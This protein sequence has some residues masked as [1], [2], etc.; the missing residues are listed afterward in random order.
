MAKETIYMGS[1]HG[2]FEFKRKLIGLLKSRGYKLV[3]VGPASY[4]KEDDFV[5][6]A[7]KA[8]GEILAR[9]GKGILICRSGHGMA[10]V[11]NKFPGI[12]ATVCW[13]KNSAVQGKKDEDINVICLP[14]DM[15]GVEEGEEIALAWLNT[16]FESVERRNRRLGKIHD[17][18]KRNF[19]SL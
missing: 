4:D 12:Y 17:I 7:E 16:P 8:C 2:G 13:N 18:E 3:D 14:A 9:G 10:I 15:I 19:K 1:D 11:A 5:D 6:Y